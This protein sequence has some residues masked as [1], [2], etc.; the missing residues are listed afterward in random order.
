MVFMVCNYIL[1]LVVI[2]NTRIQNGPEGWNSVSC[3]LNE[4]LLSASSAVARKEGEKNPTRPCQSFYNVALLLDF[5]SVISHR[6]LRVSKEAGKIVKLSV[7]SWCRVTGW[8]GIQHTLRT[9]ILSAYSA[10]WILCRGGHVRALE[11]WNRNVGMSCLKCQLPQ[12]V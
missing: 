4:R 9:V 11:E 7:L 8:K 10:L 5:K 12:A 1:L 2:Y 3:A 6:A